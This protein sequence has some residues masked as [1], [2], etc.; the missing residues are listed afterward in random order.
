MGEER[1]SSDDSSPVPPL[2]SILRS[3]ADVCTLVCLHFATTSV[4]PFLKHLSSGSLFPSPPPPPLH[5]DSWLLPDYFC[6]SHPRAVSVWRG[7][8]PALTFPDPSPVPWGLPS[9]ES[10][11]CLL[12]LAPVEAASS[13][14][15]QPLSL[16]LHPRS[17]AG[18]MS[19]LLA[20]L[21]EGSP[22]ACLKSKSG[23]RKCWLVPGFLS[24]PIWTLRQYG[25]LRR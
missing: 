25:R 14:S 5:S 13:H 12:L 15:S 16:A 7:S 9:L 17:H 18:S 19:P 10:P 24:R 3:S 6:P 1:T 11:I 22:L 4:T 8:G 2:V 23:S 20:C 21:S